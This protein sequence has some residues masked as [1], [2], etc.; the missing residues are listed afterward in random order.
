MLIGYS[1]IYIGYGEFLISY[2][3]KEKHKIELTYS[4]QKGISFLVTAKFMCGFARGGK[5]KII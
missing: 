1:Y 4:S 3:H 5:K 2:C